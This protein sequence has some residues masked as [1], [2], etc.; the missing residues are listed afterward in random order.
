MW[1]VACVSVLVVFWDVY[2]SGAPDV[3][4]RAHLRR[5]RAGTRRRSAAGWICWL[6]LVLY[7]GPVL[8]GATMLLHFQSFDAFEGVGPAFFTAVPA[9]MTSSHR[10]L[11]WAV[12]AAGVVT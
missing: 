12:I 10:A 6:N 1:A 9:L 11:S 8:G 3:R 4:P 7:A 2:H 5:A